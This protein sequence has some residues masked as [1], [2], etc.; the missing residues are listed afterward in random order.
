MKKTRPLNP[1]PTNRG[2]PFDVMTLREA[3]LYLRVHVSTL[4]KMAQQKQ[5]PVTRV[6]GQWRFS[7]SRLAQWMGQGGT[8]Q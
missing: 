1:A 5:M 7:R 2:E 4:Y 6:R 3:A 8:G